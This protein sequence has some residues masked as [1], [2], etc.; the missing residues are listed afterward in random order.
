MNSSAL[1]PAQNAPQKYV[2][3]PGYIISYEKWADDRLRWWDEQHIEL[4]DF[5]NDLDETWNKKRE[6]SLK[7]VCTLNL[8][9]IY[10]RKFDEEMRLLKQQLNKTTNSEKNETNGDLPTFV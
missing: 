8:V 10:R 5:L 1:I 4:L 7:Y 2:E 3:R 9:N 6:D